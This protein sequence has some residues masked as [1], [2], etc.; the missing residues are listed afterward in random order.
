MAPTLVR[1]PFHRDRWVSEE[2]VDGWRMLAYK[3]RRSVR[4][5][6]RNAIDHTHRFHELAAAVAKLKS[7]V[8][9]LDGEVAVYDEKLVSRFHLLGDERPTEL[10]TPP[11]FMAF[12]VLQ[13]GNRDVRDYTLEHRRVILE[14]VAAE[15]VDT[16]H[17]ARRLKGTRRHGP[18][19]RRAATRAWWRRTRARPTGRGRRA[20]G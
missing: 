13:T 5:I 20:L 9:V 15:V 14:D 11:I 8:V 7:D 2:K 19:W 17:I 18:R 10:C 3:D 1:P 4:L 12:D 6:S 16:V